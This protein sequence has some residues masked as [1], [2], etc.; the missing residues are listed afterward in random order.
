MENNNSTS[1]HQ[2]VGMDV[3]GPSYQNGPPPPPLD[4]NEVMMEEKAQKWRSMNT[5]RFA[6]MGTEAEKKQQQ[7]QRK[8]QK[9]MPPEVLRRIVKEHGDMSNRKYRNDSSVY[10]GALKYVPHAVLKLLENMPM[11]WEQVRKVNVLYHVTGAITFVN[12]IPWVVEPHYIAQWS[13]MWILMRR[14]KRDRKHFRRMRFP[15]M[16][17]E[18]SPLDYEENLLDVEPL[19]PIHM[20]LD[21]DEDAAVYKWFYEHRGLLQEIDPKTGR[22]KYVTPSF[23]RWKLDV[24]AMINLHRLAEPLLSDTIDPNYFYLF[25]KN[26]FFTAK[27][28]N[29]ALPGGPKF[30]PLFRDIEEDEDWNEFNNIH[31]IIIRQKIRTEYRIAFPHMYNERPRKVSLIPYRSPPICFLKSEDPDAPP[32]EFDPIINPIPAHRQHKNDDDGADGVDGDDDFEL[33]EHVRPIL[34]DEPLYSENT[35]SGIDLYWAPRPF[36]LRSGYTRRAQDIP[37]IKSWYQEHA[38]STYP[39]KVRVSYQKLLKGYVLNEL[40]GRPPRSVGRRKLL[41]ALQSTKFFQTTKIDWVEAGLQVC[42]QGFNMLNLLIHRKVCPN[43]L[44][45]ILKSLSR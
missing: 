41:K 13:T 4:E 30:E 45:L 25:E 32:F 18:E 40:H 19:D 6:S 17:D 21:E 15:P 42:R 10:L 31:K 44:F 20:E 39:V 22:H 12:E 28:L 36:N 9:P 37:L 26:A 24:P 16:D 23:R 43:F 11:P 14:E 8:M 27:A 7:Q 33:P 1:S 34:E 5:K 3:D 35:T 38:P 29:L 2:Q